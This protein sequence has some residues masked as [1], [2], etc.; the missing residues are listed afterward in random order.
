[1]FLLNLLYMTHFALWDPGIPRTAVHECVPGVIAGVVSLR[2]FLPAGCNGALYAGIVLFYIV[3]GVSVKEITACRLG[4]ETEL[5]IE[6]A[7][8]VVDYLLF[9]LIVE[10]PDAEVFGVVL[11]SEFGTRQTKQ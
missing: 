10:H 5:L 6:L 7:E 8:H 11:C 1:M 9:G 2:A 4:I 3:Y